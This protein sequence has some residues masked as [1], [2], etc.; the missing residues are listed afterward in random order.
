MIPLDYVVVEDNDDSK[1]GQE[2][3]H[4]A[5]QVLGAKECLIPRGPEDKS[6]FDA[7]DYC[8]AYGLPRL[9]ELLRRASY[10]DGGWSIGDAEVELEDDGK[11]LQCLIQS[12]MACGQ[13]GLVSADP[14][15]GKS[16]VALDMAMH[17]VLGFPWKSDTNTVWN[18]K[19][20]RAL[21]LCGEDYTGMKRR[22]RAWKHDHNI[23]V[24][25]TAGWL[26]F[27]KCPLRLD[28]AEIGKLVTA[29]KKNGIRD[30]LLVV[31]TF[32][33]CF[34]GDENTSDDTQRFIGNIRR[35]ICGPFNI[36]VLLLHHNNK[37]TD[38][39]GGAKIR[40]NSNLWAGADFI[41]LLERNEDLIKVTL[42]KQ[43][44][45]MNDKVGYFR[46]K[47]VNLVNNDGSEMKDDCGCPMTAPLI[48]SAN[49]PPTQEPKQN[50]K[51]DPIEEACELYLGA[52]LR[53]GN[54]D[55]WTLKGSKLLLFIE[56]WHRTTTKEKFKNFRAYPNTSGRKFNIS[57]V[58][59]ECK[60]MTILDADKMDT[61]VTD[62]GTKERLKRWKA[63]TLLLVQLL[64]LAVL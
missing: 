42:Q 30:G 23:P 3:G 41:Y 57:N 43:K 14:A 16:L 48:D 9:G 13:L 52:F 54:Y 44:A 40:G 50:K 26:F 1:A 24:G 37:R 46:T 53:Y 25:A 17:V 32:I 5:A 20:H 19:R 21:Y 36:A 55:D 11:P 4:E 63:C 39:S 6:G 22:V 31:D 12:W 56:G 28:T 51:E 45:W 38:V 60:V 47:V 64:C 34:G 61:K 62:C 10:D 18:V 59:S 35:E 29:I 15:T 49:P 27:G 7:N 2:K 58:E 33:T 8:H